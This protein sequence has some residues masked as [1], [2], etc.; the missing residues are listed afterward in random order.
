[1]SQFTT[2]GIYSEDADTFSREITKTL[3]NSD[4]FDEILFKGGALI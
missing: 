4:Q 1:M 3:K 2:I